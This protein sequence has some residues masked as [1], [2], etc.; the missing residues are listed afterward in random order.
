MIFTA[1]MW[2]YLF[3]QEHITMKKAWTGGMIAAMLALATLPAPQ[4]TYASAPART[5]TTVNA[6]LVTTMR[7]SSPVAVPASTTLS[8]TLSNDSPTPLGEA[9]QLMATLTPSQMEVDLS[10]L[11][12]ITTTL[13]SSTQAASLAIGVDGLPIMSYANILFEGESEFDV[14][15]TDTLKVAKCLNITCTEV[16]S[17]TLD[18]PVRML[19]G[20]IQIGADGLPVMV[21]STSSGPQTLRFAKCTTSDCTSA[22][23]RTVDN[24]GRVGEYA[25]LAIGS[26]DLPIISYRDVD[27]TSLKVAKCQ[28]LNCSS[29]LLTTIDNSGNNGAFNDIAIAQNGFANIS[30]KDSDAQKMKLARCQNLDCTSASNQ[31]VDN[32]ESH[33]IGSVIWV[34]SDGKPYILYSG[35][36]THLMKLAKCQDADCTGVDIMVLDNVGQLGGDPAMAFANDGRPV[37]AYNN[38]TKNTMMMAVCEDDAC[39]SVITSTLPIGTGNSVGSD[40]FE[41]GSDGLPVFAY[42]LNGKLMVAKAYVSLPTYSIDYGD[43]TPVMTGTWPVSGVLPLSHTYAAA[44]SY[45]ATLT[46][47]SADGAE[48]VTATSLV[49]VNSTNIEGLSGKLSAVFGNVV[50]YTLVVSNANPTEALQNVVISGSVPAS[51]TLVSTDGISNTAGGDFGAGYASKGPLTLGPGQQITLTWSVRPLTR[52]GDLFTRGHALSDNSAIELETSVRVYR[53]YFGIIVREGTL[54]LQ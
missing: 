14:K 33:G 36:T 39:S 46:A 23:T 25:S 1:A 32:T 53:L 16:V 38:Y 2:F 22:I 54:P 6:S 11:Q 43:S 27:N 50:T 41:I 40:Y 47:T 8:V 37:M 5:L 49:Q 13:D 45:T 17:S 34:A 20:E 18:V 30:H 4:G 19:N 15:I 52:V 21:Y 26:D 29:A 9:T 51:T 12:W 24:A 3:H 44:G 28:D 48:V 42:S 31:I 35:S 7:V 10:Q